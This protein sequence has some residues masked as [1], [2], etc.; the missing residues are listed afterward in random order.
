MA[1][2]GTAYNAIART[3]RRLTHTLRD[4]RHGS[5]TRRYTTRALRG[6]V[7]S[8]ANTTLLR[9]RACYS[10]RPILMP[11]HTTEATMPPIAPSQFRFLMPS[12]RTSG[13]PEGGSARHDLLAPHPAVSRLASPGA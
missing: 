9:V 4:V 13:C 1:G 2:K 6:L 8:G 3:R 10:L 7:G 12:S 11:S 5:P